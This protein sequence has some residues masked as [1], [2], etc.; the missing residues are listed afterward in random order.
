MV[1]DEGIFL[2]E[3]TTRRLVT[4]GLLVPALEQLLGGRQPEVDHELDDLADGPPVAVLEAASGPPFVVVEGKRLSL[5]GLPLPHPVVSSSYDRLAEGPELDLVRSATVRRAN[6]AIGWLADTAAPDAGETH[7][8]WWIPTRASGW[9]R[10]GDDAGWPR[11]CS[12]PRWS[13]LVGPRQRVDADQLA[14]WEE[15][16][17]V[18]VLE[19]RTGPPFVVIGGHPPSPALAAGPV[20]GGRGR[21]HPPARG[22][23]AG[24]GAGHRPPATR[25]GPGLA[26]GRGA[27]AR[28]PTR[29]GLGARQHHLGARGLDPAPGAIRTAGARPRGAA[30]RPASGH[31]RGARPSP[32]AGWWRCWRAGEGPPFLVVGG[33][34][35][36][37]RSLPVPFP[38]SEAGASQ[39]PQGAEL[40]V[41]LLSRRL[42]ELTRREAEMSRQLAEREANPDPV[43]ELKAYLGKKRPR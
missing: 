31:R 27:G 36:P 38:V 4:S 33:V 39:L 3:G 18:E 29:A 24:R 26:R 28:P 14:G 1:G 40:D 11:P 15:A 41:A 42:N 13:S 19:S 6:D 30:R 23:A 43:G 12:S 25:P 2:V 5:R 16:T 10:A 9:S 22:S 34:R 35:H 8:W 37:L 20:P 17:P 32:R 21:R 7:A